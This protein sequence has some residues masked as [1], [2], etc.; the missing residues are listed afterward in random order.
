MPLISA[1][2]DT[3]TIKNVKGMSRAHSYMVRYPVDGTGGYKVGVVEY[4]GG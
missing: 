2:L 4:H 3:E 1:P